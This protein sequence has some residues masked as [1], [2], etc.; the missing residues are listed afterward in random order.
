MGGIQV[1]FIGN[2][3]GNLLGG[4]TGAKQQSEAAQQASATQA[5]AAQAGIDEQKRQ[6]DAFQAA[7]APYVQAGTGA[8]GAQQNLIGLGGAPAQQQAI[9]ALQSSPQFQALNQQGTNAILQNAAAT[10]GLRGGNTQ[11][12]LAQFSPALLSQLIQQQYANL[13]GLTS[14]GQSSAAGVGNAG[15]QTGSNIA[16]LLQQQG[17][18]TAGGQMAAGNLAHQ[19]FVEGGKIASTIAS[20]FGGGKGGGGSSQF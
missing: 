12:A 4:I 20:F 5:Q 10:G 15:L 8:L 6:F 7:L 2:T 3:V 14:L 16:G 13:G 11:A 1:S 9:Q 19:A 17:A 18:A